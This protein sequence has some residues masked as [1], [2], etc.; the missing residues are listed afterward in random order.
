[1]IEG[2]AS[3][4]LGALAGRL[5]AAGDGGLR[6]EL[7]AGLRSGVRPIIPAL[8]D[9]ARA[10][11]PHSGGLG[12]WV[13]SSRFTVRNRLSVESASVS[14]VNRPAKDTSRRGGGQAQFGTDKGVVRH[15]VFGHLDRWATTKVH[16]GW[17]SRTVEDHL[18][19]VTAE[20]ESVVVSVGEKLTRNLLGG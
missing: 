16:G 4:E 15:P 14:I 11:L 2:T 9:A 3:A 7:L 18:P 13:A 17:F 20:V 5:K 10:E 1:M 6:R 19:H 8:Q 12:E